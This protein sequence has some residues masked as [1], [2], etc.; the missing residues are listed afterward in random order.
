MPIIDHIEKIVAPASSGVSFPYAY[1]PGAL[2]RSMLVVLMVQHPFNA[3]PLDTVANPITYAGQVLDQNLIGQSTG[4]GGGS[5]PVVSCL[6]FSRTSFL[7]ESALSG[8]VIVPSFLF[9]ANAI[10]FAIGMRGVPQAFDQ[11]WSF[12]QGNSIPSSA[13]AVSMDNPFVG[14]IGAAIKEEATVTSVSGTAALADEA[15]IHDGTHSVTGSIVLVPAGQNLTTVFLSGNAG[16]GRVGWVPNA[17]VDQGTD[18]FP[19]PVATGPN[20]PLSPY[21]RHEIRE[22]TGRDLA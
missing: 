22:R 2:G 12:A 11:R 15:V 10:V 14:I 21:F 13:F 7:V 4:E 9:P 6:A 19:P 5:T 3:F 17:Y 8:D 20:R 16:S 1:N 18:V